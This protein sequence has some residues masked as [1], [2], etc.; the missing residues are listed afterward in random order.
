MLAGSPASRSSRCGSMGMSIPRLEAVIA[1]PWPASQ[2]LADATG[3]PPNCALAPANRRSRAVR[4]GDQRDKR[5]AVVAADRRDRRAGGSAGRGLTAG[6]L[7]IGSVLMR[8]GRQ[9]EEP[10]ASGRTTEERNDGLGLETRT[11]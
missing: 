2:E 3:S 11:A 8:V 9:P 7:V 5:P 1:R 10:V 4:A 6:V